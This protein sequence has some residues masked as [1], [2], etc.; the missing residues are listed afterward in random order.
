MNNTF[1]CVIPLIS[2]D[3]ERTKIHFSTI[4]KKLCVDEVFFIGPIDLKEHISRDI[5]IGFWNNYKIEI[6]N[7]NELVDLNKL[8]TIYDILLVES[9]NTYP[10][11]VNWY[12]QQFLKMSFSMICNSEYYLCWDS[13]TIPLRN[14]SMFN[15]EGKPYLDIK[16]ENNPVYFQ[17]IER[18]F[19]YSKIIEKSFVSEHMLFSKSIMLEIINVIEN[20]PIKGEK[21][22]EKIMWAVGS[23][24]LTLGF[25]E[26]ETYGSYIG[27][28]YPDKYA[29]RN[30]KSF[31]N[32]NFFVDISELNEDDIKWLAKDYDAASFEKYQETEVL[33]NQLFRNR[34]YREKLSPEQF[35]ISILESGA[36]GDYSDGKLKIGNNY[37]PI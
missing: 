13:D 24:N 7:E 20:K 21:F 11:S 33:L 36:M 27:I 23:D 29:L 3:Y 16:K 4:L 30:W 14:I 28:N 31:R 37:Y 17:T 8:K 15:K 6:I 12:Y 25:S 18:L 1:P 26:F 35:Y 10:S 34:R 5:S 19:G 32:L 2:S 22:Y 9:G